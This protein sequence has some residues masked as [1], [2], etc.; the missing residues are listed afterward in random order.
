MSDYVKILEK[1]MNEEEK[2][3]KRELKNN[4]KDQAVYIGGII[5]GLA[6]A[7]CEYKNKFDEVDLFECS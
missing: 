7:L 5:A 4:D 2:E 3:R 1:Y 6:I